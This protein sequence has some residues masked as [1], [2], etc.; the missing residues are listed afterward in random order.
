[1]IAARSPGRWR[2]SVPMPGPA[3]GGDREEEGD[4]DADGRQP[5]RLLGVEVGL[6]DDARPCDRRAEQGRGEGRGDRRPARAGGRRRRQEPVSRHGDERDRSERDRPAEEHEDARG[7][8]SKAGACDVVEDVRGQP[9]IRDPHHHRDD[10]ERRPHRERLDEARPARV[11]V[12]V[13]APRL[14]GSIQRPSRGRS[15]TRAWGTTGRDG[16]SRSRHRRPSSARTSVASSI[17]KPTPMH[18]RVPP[19]NSG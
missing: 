9:G 8:G 15:D 5:V 4:P 3:G 2:T 19:P 18:L 11:R 6:V 10:A 12:G 1:M 14:S 16:S 17:A 13:H 7:A